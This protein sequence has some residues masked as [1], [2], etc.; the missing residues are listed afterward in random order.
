MT[1]IG[2]FLVALLALPATS[3]AGNLGTNLGGINYYDGQVVFSN[4]V[5]QGGEWIG[6]DFQKDKRG[7][8]TAISAPIQMAIAELHYPTGNYKVTWKGQGTFRV[9]EKTFSGKNGSGSVFLDGSSLV[10]LEIEKSNRKNY[11]R[12]IR[13]LTP[14]SNNSA[15]RP[16]YIKSLRPYKTLRFMDWQK[17]NGT[18]SDPAPRLSCKDALGA[19]K[20]SQGQRRGVSVIW[21]VKLS[22]LVRANPWFNVPHRATQAWLKCHARYV[23]NNLG[24]GL[25]PRYEFSNETWN[26]AFEQYHDMAAGGDD[27]FLTAQIESARRHNQMVEIIEQIITKRRWRSVLAG[28]AANSWVLEERLKIANADEIAIAPYMHIG[29]LYD[30]TEAEEWAEKTTDQVF[31]ALRESITRE[32]SPWIN[33]HLS[34]GK[35]LIT[36]EGGQHLAGFSE[37][38]RLTNLLIESNRDPRMEGLYKDYLSLWREKTGNQLFV[39]F[40]DS[41]P[42]TRYGSWGAL[43]NPE[44]ETSPKYRALIDFRFDK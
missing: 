37:N 44:M 10:L 13:V 14:G 16:E 27:P 15:F 25:I 30:P 43:E 11:L 26:P 17:T 4:L 42:Y 36:Y 7:W 29:N 35:P 21:M 28:Q 2:I 9:G 22:N 38:D 39:H 12:D 20:I 32:V 41:G 34:L 5:R 3:S 8:P 6:D 33:D 18:F 23:N 24:K 1:I 19:D 40:T 31:T